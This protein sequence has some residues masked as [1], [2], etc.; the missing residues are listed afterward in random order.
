[1]RRGVRL[2]VAYFAGSPIPLWSA[3]L[4]RS[5]GQ[6]RLG[7]LVNCCSPFDL[8]V[9]LAC[10]VGVCGYHAGG[11]AQPRADNRLHGWTHFPPSGTARG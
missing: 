7:R 9:W 1:M 10:G 4:A 11:E 8:L 6:G 2:E 3:S 5:L